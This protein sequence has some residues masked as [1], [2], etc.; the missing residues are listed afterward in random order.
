M[1]GQYTNFILLFLL[2]GC[3]E[4]LKQPQSQTLTIQNFIQLTVPAHY[5]VV[6]G[7]GIDS[8][9]YYI[10]TDNNDSVLIEYGHKG[11]INDLYD[12]PVSV[13]SLDKKAWVVKSLGRETTEEDALFSEFP[14]EDYEQR[15]FQKNFSMYD[16]INNIIVKVVQP[17]RIGN[18]ITGVH[19]PKLENEMS[20]S[21]SAQNLDSVSHRTMLDMFK[22]LRYK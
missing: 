5:Q 17:K 4:E 18:G 8:D 6:K 9:I 1:K 3:T 20:L 10:V 7:Q 21:I 11:I 19:I 22:T 16:T 12:S 2:L 13:F 14:E 15:I